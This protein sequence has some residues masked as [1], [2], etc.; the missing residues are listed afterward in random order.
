M[1]GQ[2]VGSRAGGKPVQASAA[3]ATGMKR[4]FGAGDRTRLL[5]LRSV[6]GELF[7]ERQSFGNGA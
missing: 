1:V 3:A 5:S 2:D 6:F 4:V 7:E